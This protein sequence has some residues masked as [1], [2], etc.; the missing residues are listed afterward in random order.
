MRSPFRHRTA[1][2]PA[3]S[4]DMFENA[5]RREGFD[6]D[7]S[8]LEAARTL[9]DDATWCYLVGPPG[10]GKSWLLDTYTAALPAGIPLRLHWHEFTRDLHRCIRTAGSLPAGLARLLG[11]H[12]V[13][14]FDE[15]AVD[16]PADGI[17]VDRLFAAARAAHVR[18]VVTSNVRPRELMPNP[19]FHDGFA[20]TIHLIERE[21]TVAELDAGV[22]YRTEAHTSS[23][24]SAGRW[25]VGERETADR[26]ADALGEHIDVNGRRLRVLR[27]DD[28][29]L[30]VDFGELCGRPLGATDYLTLA[31]RYRRWTVVGVTDLTDAGS[32]PAQRFLHLVDV[33]Y[34]NDVETSFESRLPLE[35]FG[36]RDLLPPRL[37]SRLGQLNVAPIP[38]S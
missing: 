23:G 1:T 13:L 29:G 36:R 11:S 9:A 35:D 33:L 16:D 4:P 26:R 37:L 3:L 28:D 30:V 8:Q 20:P 38:I 10:R 17:F 15:F 25:I 34:D 19:L 6:L 12:T 18:L 31:D 24:F 7:S 2:P 22:D 14:C 5:A 32:E 27:A 21:F